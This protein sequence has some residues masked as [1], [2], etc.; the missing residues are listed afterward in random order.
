MDTFFP[1]PAE[2]AAVM[3]DVCGDLATARLLAECNVDFATSEDQLLYWDAVLQ[4]L[5]PEV[6]ACGA[7]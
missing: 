5:T 2:H 6:A 7:N 4:A 1:N 3:L